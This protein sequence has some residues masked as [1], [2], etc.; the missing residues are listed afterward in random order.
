MGTEILSLQLP[1]ALISTPGTKETHGVPSSS[2]WG[3]SLSSQGSLVALAGI[4]V[5]GIVGWGWQI[6]GMLPGASVRA[7]L[8][9]WALPAAPRWFT[10]LLIPLCGSFVVPPG[11]IPWCSGIPI[12]FPGSSIGSL[13]PPG[14]SQHCTGGVSWGLGTGSSLDTGTPE[15][16]QAGDREQPAH[17]DTRAIPGWGLGTG[18]SQAQLAGHSLLPASGSRD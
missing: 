11:R 14:A 8:S 2:S 4:D 5:A 13:I 7:G 1:L 6:L 3:S 16:S 15:P 18:I 9:V 12:P 10:A 17:R